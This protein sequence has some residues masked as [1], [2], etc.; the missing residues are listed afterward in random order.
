MGPL[1]WGA[2]SKCLTKVVDT[3]CALV[4]C[5]GVMLLS[6]GVQVRI[7]WLLVVDFLRQEAV[8][9]VHVSRNGKRQ[10]TS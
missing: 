5:N 3:A 7:A 2:L 6:N 9:C 8:G 10:E 1:V 4:S